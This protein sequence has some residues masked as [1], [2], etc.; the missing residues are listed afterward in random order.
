MTGILAV[1]LLLG[2]PFPWNAEMGTAG[3][4]LVSGGPGNEPTWGACG[5]G[6]SLPT[7]AIVLIVSGTCPTGFT[8][9]TSL[10]GKFVLGTV[11]ANAD[12]GTTGGQDTVTTVLNHTHTVNVSDPQHNHTQNAHT[13]VVTSQT[14]TTGSATSYEHGVLD[15]SSAEAE[16]TEVTGSTT[17]TNNAASTGVTATTANP[18][19]GVASIDNR[20][21]FIRVIFCRAN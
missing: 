6:A 19:G 17:A 14:A 10:N 3:Q 15:T 21:A 5:G 8:Q 7:G 20:P 16:V 13:H 4:C 11:A 12:I 9:E 1:L 2:V 18:G